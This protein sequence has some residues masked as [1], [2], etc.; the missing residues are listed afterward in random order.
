VIIHSA[1]QYIAETGDNKPIVVA[2]TASPYKFAADVLT[3]L[4]GENTDDPLKALELLSKQTNTEITKPLRDLDKREVRFT[5]VIS[6]ENM[7]EN[8][9]NYAK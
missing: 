2:S 6:P 9:R 1:K 4:D 3:S 5:K 7:L 8:V